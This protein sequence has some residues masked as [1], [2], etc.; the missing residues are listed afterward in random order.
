[1]RLNAFNELDAAG[2]D[3]KRI[4]LNGTNAILKQIFIDGF[5]HADPHPANIFAFPDNSICFLDLGMFG[6][7]DEEQKGKM[8]L[9]FVSMIKGNI[10][11]YIRY[12]IEFAETS[13]KSDVPGFKKAIKELFVS[14]YGF[15][16]KERSMAH[17]FFDGIRTG[18]K[19]NVFFPSN[20]VML[21]K[22]LLTFEAVAR[23]LDPDFNLTLAAGPFVEELYVETMVPQELIRL[24]KKSSTIY[25][26]F[27]HRLFKLWANALGKF[28][29]ES[30]ELLL[31][32][33]ELEQEILHEKT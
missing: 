10:H 19:Y 33:E 23:D 1:V 20:L 22:V 8:L 16:V 26:R 5:F 7:F 12:L 11:D 15:S 6:E 14:V 24:F 27:L 3:K 18:V 13:E 9:I 30:L 4:A 21:A 28:E 29:E 17:A 31:D 32:E 25:I 2:T